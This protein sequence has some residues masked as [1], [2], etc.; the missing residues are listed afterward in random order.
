MGGVGVRRLLSMLLAVL[1]YIYAHTHTHTHTHTQRCVLKM[2]KCREG[3]KEYQRGR[4]RER[5]GERE[6]E[7]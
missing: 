7:R 1:S 2:G 5:G 3:I 4:K 6:G